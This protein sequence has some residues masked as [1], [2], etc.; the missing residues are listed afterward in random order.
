[1]EWIL[2][3]LAII[4]WGWYSGTVV[5]EQAVR[6]ARRACETHRQQLLDE[7]VALQGF[8]PRRDASGRM[9]LLRRYGFEFSGDGDVRHRGTIELLGM[10]VTAIDLEMDGFTLYEQSPDE[11]EGPL[12]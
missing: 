9:R 1:V 2:V 10:K 3:A 7:T 11:S 5:K 12:H 4:A 8:R 6:A